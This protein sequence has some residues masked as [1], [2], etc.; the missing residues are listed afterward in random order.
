MVTCE[1]IDD[2]GQNQR[3]RQKQRENTNINSEVKDMMKGVDHL[4]LHHMLR[5]AGCKMTDQPPVSV[6]LSVD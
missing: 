2:F 5:Q 4:P 1:N 6:G 3:L